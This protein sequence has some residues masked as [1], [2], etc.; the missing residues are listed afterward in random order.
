[1]PRLDWSPCSYAPGFQCATAEVP[2]DHRHPGGRTIDLAVI[3]RPAT[4]P[5]HRAGSLFFNPG[6]PGNAT[7]GT[8]ALPVAYEAF[9]RELRERFDIVSWDPRGVGR[10][11]AVRCFTSAEEF[12]AWSARVP[13]G[14]PVGARERAAW[15]SAFAELGR[16]CQQRVPD[17][18]RHVST[19]DTA[20]D[21]DLLRQAVGERGLN[22]L[23]VS[24]GT[25]LGATY[26][27]LFPG[28][29][30]AMVLDGGVDP[31]TWT[32]P[33]PPLPTDLR[34]RAD[35]GSA[36]T[37]AR[38][39]DLCGR[40]TTDRCAFSAG[41]PRATRDKFERLLRRLAAQPQG[42]WT[43][44]ATVAAVVEGLYFVDPGWTDLAGLLQA[45]WEGRAPSPSAPDGPSGASETSTAAGKSVTPGRSPAAQPPV[46]PEIEPP[47][48]VQCSESPVPRDTRLYPAFEKYAHAR[49]GDVGRYW[50][51]L[52]EPCAT[53]PARAAAPYTGPWNR[54]TPPLLTVNT[55]YDPATPYP[56][57]VSLTG[58]LAHARLI[59]VRGYGHTALLNPSQCVSDHEVRYF[60]AGAL[61]P[62]G[63]VCDQDVQPFAPGTEASTPDAP[64]PDAVPPGK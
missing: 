13:D 43:Y 26:A 20:R 50:T 3:R 6:G 44:A 32:R 5:A 18:L 21:L 11:T 19:A 23:G 38:F 49:S 39:L 48:A 27:N 15:I 46:Y 10:S 47:Y 4:D 54:P 24:Y 61:P 58:R 51:W 9:P 45:L 53:W 40:T 36:Q 29:V 16:L 55:T 34:A 59:T 42:E 7:A 22:Y 60:L 64:A 57:A 28:S 25:F 31:V 63:A 41:T 56:Q 37:L 8:A 12:A 35:V 33:S 30:R 17:L 2:L 62:R 14:F 52:S 1:M